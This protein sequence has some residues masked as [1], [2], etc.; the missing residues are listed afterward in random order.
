LPMC[1]FFDQMYDEVPGSRTQSTRIP[2]RAGRTP[3][4]IQTMRIKINRQMSS[5]KTRILA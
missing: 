5:S 2:R 3:S 4:G 1:S